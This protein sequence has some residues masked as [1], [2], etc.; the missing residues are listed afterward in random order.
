V[1]SMEQTSERNFVYYVLNSIFCVVVIVSNIISP[2][3]VKLP[4]FQ[5]FSIPAGLITY[6]LTFFISDLVTEIYGARMAK[7]MVYHAFGMSIVAYLIIKI[8]LILPSSSTENQLY[9][10]KILGLNGVILIAS[11]TAYI[12]SQI[13]DIQLY[14]LIR[15]WTGENYLW[16]RNNGATLIAQ[17]V[18]TTIVNMIYLK[19]GAGM[20]MSQVFPIMIFSYVYKCVFSMAFTPLFYFF[21]FVFKRNILVRRV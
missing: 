2:K 5:D 19:M 1:D 20:E 14:A 17:L 8:A 18:D 21:V 4:Y 9:F 3:M 13:I 12:F 10:E 11:L 6:P 15:K 16:L 7:E